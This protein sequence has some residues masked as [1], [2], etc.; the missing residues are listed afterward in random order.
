[1]IMYWEKWKTIAKD[2]HRW[3]NHQERG[4]LKAEY[5]GNYQLRLWFEEDLDVSI[6]DLDFY[7]LLI[8]EDPGEV[9]R[10]LRD[11]AYFKTA[12]GHYTLNWFDPC[13]IEQ[14]P[15][16]TIELAPECVRYFCQ[17]SGIPRKLPLQPSELK[18]T[19]Q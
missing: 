15:E 7:P 16:T 5:L 6:Y 17:T 8:E 1:M 11:I 10:S 4:L 12:Q 13:C 2:P 9:L 18:L 3:Q 14:Q 19:K